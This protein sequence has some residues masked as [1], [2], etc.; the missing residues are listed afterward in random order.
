[1]A[2]EI[3]PHPFPIPVILPCI[4]FVGGPVLVL[5]VPVVTEM[6]FTD[7]PRA[8]IPYVRRVLFESRAPLESDDCFFH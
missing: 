7:F 8:T 4:Q 1:M 3:P 5:L 6:D 2:G